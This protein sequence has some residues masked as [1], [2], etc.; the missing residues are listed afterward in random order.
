MAQQFSKRAEKATAFQHAFS[1]RSGIECVTHE[2]QT[3]TDLDDRAT[4]VSVDGIGAYDLIARQAMSSGLQQPLHVLV[5]RRTWCRARDP[6]RRRGRTA[7]VIQYRTA[8]TLVAI[9]SERETVRLAVDQLIRRYDHTRKTK[10][11]NRAGEEPPDCEAM[12]RVAVLVD[13]EAK[14]WRGYVSQPLS[15]QGLKIFGTP[16]GQPEFIRAELGNLIA[17]HRVLLDRIP[18]VNDLHDIL[19]CTSC[20]ILPSQSPPA[21]PRVRHGTRRQSVAVFLR[22]ARVPP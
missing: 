8:S 6:A 4:V 9:A 12:Q 11:W 19:R 2:L 14:V 17:K 5:G 22:F 3:L 7:N 16:V 15:E 18:A 13:P 1:T 20:Q 10:V 21:G